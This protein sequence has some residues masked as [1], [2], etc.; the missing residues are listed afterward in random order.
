MTINI[1][2]TAANGRFGATAAV[3]PRTILCG[4]ERLYPAGSVVGA[5]TTPSRWDV[6]RN[7]E[8][9]VRKATN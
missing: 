9:T 6:A 2:K 1:E 5:A 3:T 8:E 7:G 4:N